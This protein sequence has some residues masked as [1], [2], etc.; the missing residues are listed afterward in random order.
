MHKDELYKSLRE[1]DSSETFFV[2]DDIKRL[3][4]EEYVRDQFY[5]A[6]D[7][8]ESCL[9]MFNWLQI[10]ADEATAD[11]T[12]SEE[13]KETKTPSLGI[14]QLSDGDVINVVKEVPA[15]AD[16]PMMEKE[17]LQA[18]IIN[19]LTNC[20][21]AYMRAGHFGEAYLTA[22]YMIRIKDDYHKGYYC[23]A[24][25]LLYNKSASLDL[26]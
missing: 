18:V 19:I 7:Y 1:R 14:S 22:E 20:F 16:D 3:G 26:F 21:C 25:S 10:K 2:L 13:T 24:M 8:Y 12:K 4:N 17:S 15:D 23:R 11:E 6:L 9:S 5:E